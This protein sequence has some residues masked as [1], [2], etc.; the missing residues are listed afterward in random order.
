MPADSFSQN[1][2]G[3]PFQCD[4]PEYMHMLFPHRIDTLGPHH[5][6][7]RTLFSPADCTQVAQA[8]LVLWASPSLRDQTH[9]PLFDTF[10]ADQEQRPDKPSRASISPIACLAPE[11]YEFRDV[12][13]TQ[14]CRNILSKSRA[15]CTN[16][17]YKLKWK[18]FC[19]WCK[20]NNLHPFQ[21]SPEQILLYL[22]ALA[23]SGLGYICLKVHLAAI[24]K[25]RRSSCTLSF[26]SSRLV[27]QF[28]K[29]LFQTFPPVRAL[30]PE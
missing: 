16:K 7:G 24:S 4:G 5:N 25:Y 1:H 8:T 12:E 10:T 22:F 26:C 17:T 27:K 2:G 9:S 19:I 6:E 23:K 14:E 18:R 15:E 13:I 3:M 28:I 20:Q 30:P 29:G 21:A 11:F